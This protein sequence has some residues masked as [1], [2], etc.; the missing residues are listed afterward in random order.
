MI[1]SDAHFQ[2]KQIFVHQTESPTKQ[3]VNDIKVLSHKVE[4][5]WSRPDCSL[6]S[7]LCD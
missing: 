2:Q 6:D 7:D 4:F 5:F 1:S 3:F